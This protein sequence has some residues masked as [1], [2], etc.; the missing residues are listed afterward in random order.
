M[1]LK[2]TSVWTKLLILVLV[3]YAVV[4]LVRLQDRV[5]N[6]KAEVAQLEEQVLYAEQEKALMEESL[7]DLGS[8]KSI[9]QIA[10][11]RLGMVESGEIV[12]LDADA[13]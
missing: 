8:D 1:R 4:S 6:A 12:F 11:A 10:R 9:M 2:K 7:R 13:Q 3:V 5:T